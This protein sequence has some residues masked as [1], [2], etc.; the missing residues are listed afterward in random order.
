MFTAYLIYLTTTVI[1][2]QN[3]I[4]QQKRTA[5]NRTFYTENFASWHIIMK[6]KFGLH[7]I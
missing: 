4:K 5:D 6:F 1:T 2:D 3:R 7:E